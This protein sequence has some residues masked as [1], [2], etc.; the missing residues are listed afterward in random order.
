MY[1]LLTELTE[2]MAAI[3]ERTLR[4]VPIKWE[5]GVCEQIEEEVAA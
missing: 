2:F 3:D 1:A 4:L 5:G